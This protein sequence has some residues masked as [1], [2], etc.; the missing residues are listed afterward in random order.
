MSGAPTR[1]RAPWITRRRCGACTTS[2]TR[3]TSTRSGDHLAG[4]FVEHE[5][6]PGLAPTKDG[7][8]RFFQLYVAGFPDL[9][10]DVQDILT[11]GDK[12]VGRFRAS[13]TH[14][15]EFMGMAPTGKPVDV[16]GIDIIRF[17][18]DGLAHQHRGVFDAL[19]MMQ[20]LGVVPA[21]P[22]G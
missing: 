11:S 19:G 4:D 7:V 20:Q 5:A 9:R 18:D 6:A 14:E 1:R 3:T 17:A 2:S 10:F 21:G 16:E 12:I 8:K 13:G 22:P 15:G